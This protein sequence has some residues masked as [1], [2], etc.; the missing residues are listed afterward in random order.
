MVGVRVRIFALMPNQLEIKASHKPIKEYYTALEDYKRIGVTKETTVRN[1]FQELL[2]TYAKKLKWNFVEEYGITLS[3][4]NKGSVDGA[5]VDAYNIVMGYWE[6]KD[7]DDDFKKEIKSKFDKGYPR[8]N[9]LFQEPLKAVLYQDGQEVDAYDLTKPE[10]LVNCL[11]DF[12]GYKMQ[13]QANWEEI[14]AQFKDRIPDSAI[15]LVEMIEIEKKTNTKFKEA[16]KNFAVLCRA[17]INPNLADE[18]IEEMLVQHLLTSRIFASVFNNPEFIRRNA[19]AAEIEKVIDAL[20]S[21]SFNKKDFFEPL[22]HFY[23]QLEKRAETI[24]DWAQKQAFLNTVYEKF[25]QGYAVK[26]ADTHGIVYTPQPIVDFMVLSVEHILKTEFGRSLGSDGVHILDPFVGTGNFMMRIMR[27]IPKTK[28]PKKYANELHCNEIMLLPYYISSMNIEHEYFAQTGDYKPFE[29]I[30][31][32]DTFELAESK[33]Q[34]QA[35]VSENAKRIESQQASKIFVVVGN[36]P[37]NA[38]QVNEN[39]N[40]KNRKY[41]ALDKRVNTTYSKNSAA[42]NKNALSDPYVKAFRF[43]SD[44]VIRNGEG[45]LAF[46]SNNSFLNDFAFDGMRKSLRQDFDEIYVLDLGGN[47]RKNP[48]LSGTTHNV[49]GIQVGVSINILVRRPGQSEKDGKVFYARIEEFAKKG[50]KYKYLNQAVGIPGVSWENLIPDSKNNWITEGMEKG[51][52]EFISLG[53]KESK[54]DEDGHSIFKTYGRGVATGRDTWTYNFNR[55]ILTVNIAKTAEFFNEQS[56][57]Y[58]RLPGAIRPK[59]DD[60]VTY[61]D[62]KISW[63]RDLKLD[64]KRSKTA[65]FEESKIRI[66]LYRPFLK[67]NLFFDRILN[68]EVYQQPESFPKSETENVVICVRAVGSNAPF[69]CIITNHI[70]DLHLTGDSQCFPFYIYDEDGTNRRENIT[71]WAVAQF[72]LKAK[73]EKLKGGGEITKW[74]IFYY[75]YGLLHHPEYRKKYAANLRRELPRI[76]ISKDF[77]AFSEA[78]KKL[79]DLHVNYEQEKEYELEEVWKKDSTLDLRVEKMKQSKDKL[80]LIY[81]DK[82]T[83]RGIPPE[84]FDYKLGNRSALDWVIDQYQVSTDKRS[85]I[86]N[87]PNREDEPDY[88]V[89]L[90]RKVITVSLETV[91]VVKGIEKLSME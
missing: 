63:S 74:D 58:L 34:V 15:K 78:G 64:L 45:I 5:I 8:N 31:L 56:S 88:I 43:A 11:E 80:D 66:S 18:A 27:E 91:K 19:I 25:F 49:F 35:F 89:N 9:I 51:F 38:W 47:V 83:L 79:A 68:E 21:R 29:G 42:T 76:P 73:S 33:G 70:P 14:V 13:E 60:F 48:K 36:P 46:V 39:D 62:T 37:Y 17:S 3:N 54:K 50:E 7:S 59:P 6:A 24:T 67:T 52:D 4:K 81:N 61:D 20:T 55:D 16:F 77:W 44:R 82:L 69:H 32:V 30:C 90:I 1:A 65:E 85:G 41:E 71:D 86:T 53:S 10:R 22:E 87:D 72:K 12:F 2:S 40:N 75:L 28:L 84:V 26:V 23:R 57:K